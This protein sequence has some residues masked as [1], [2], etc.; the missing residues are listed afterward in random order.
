MKLIN[1]IYK[2][3]LIALLVFGVACSDLEEEPRN[4]LDPE[5]FFKSARD[6]ETAVF[7][8]HTVLQSRWLYGSNLSLQLLVRSDMA[9][10]GGNLAAIQEAALSDF[11]VDPTLASDQFIA[12]TYIFLF[13]GIGAANNALRG[14]DIIGDGVPGII[15]LRAEARFLRGF[16]YYHLVRM[17]GGVTLL[18]SLPDDPT[19]VETL[20]RNSEDEVYELIL[21][22]LQFAKENLPDEYASGGRSRPTKGTAAAYLAS[23][24]LTRENYATAYSEAKFV[25]DNSSRFNYDL[26]S[27]FANLFD[28]TVSDNSLE[29]LFLIDFQNNVS[30]GNGG[31]NQDFYPPYITPLGMRVFNNRSGWSVAGPTLAVFDSW[32]D[33]DYRKDVSFVTE[34]IAP[35]DITLV[36]EDGVAGTADDVSYTAGD[37]VPYTDWTQEWSSNLRPRPYAAKYVA[38]P[39]SAGGAGNQSDNNYIAMRYAEVLLIAAEATIMGGGGSE[40][41]AIGYINQLRARA[42]G[43][44]S[45]AEAR[46]VPADFIGTLTRADIIEERRLEFAFEWKRWYDIKRLQIG[47]D[48]F[49]PNGLEPQPAFNASRDYLWPIPQNVIQLNES[50]N[51]NPGY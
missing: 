15:E 42:R 24:N 37:A 14:A 50:I 21:A 12:N 7:G 23:V 4:V 39:G 43:G 46:N 30:P 18:E 2:S 31:T 40:A 1:K 38:N 20:G 32:E 5:T 49:G 29:P 10:N 34:G 3:I 51:Q 6:V 16:M 47:D 44:L 33:E 41:E 48:V 27:D 22:D 28:A 36:G 19:T 25:I 9:G 13:R 45:G 8:A 17:Y 35:R 26:E 11:S